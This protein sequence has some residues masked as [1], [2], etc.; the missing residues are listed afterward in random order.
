MLREY[1]VGGFER[2]F[3]VGEGVDATRI[4]ASLE[5]GVLTITLPKAEAAKPRKINIRGV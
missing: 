3:R 4:D 1:P 2:T 5:G